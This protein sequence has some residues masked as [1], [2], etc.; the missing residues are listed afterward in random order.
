MERLCLLTL[1]AIIPCCAQTWTYDVSAPWDGQMD[2]S[3]AALGNVT[4]T[5]YGEANENACTPIAYIQPSLVEPAPWSTTV[6]GP[7]V[8]ATYPNVAVSTISGPVYGANFTLNGIGW[9]ATNVKCAQPPYVVCDW[10]AISIFGHIFSYSQTYYSHPIQ[11]GTQNGNILCSYQQPDCTSGE[12]SC[13]QSPGGPGFVAQLSVSGCP[14][15]CLAF[16][17]HKDFT[18]WKSINVGRSITMSDPRPCSRLRH[19]RTREPTGG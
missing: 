8:G 17:I 12:P 16:W 6:W 4:Y 3:S 2:G 19:G 7:R 5:T 13:I 10:F 15:Y 1:F 18:C 14:K 11:I 9:Y